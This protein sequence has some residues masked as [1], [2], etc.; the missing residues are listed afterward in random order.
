MSHVAA[1]LALAAALLLAT[2]AAAR[3]AE[4]PDPLSPEA[5]DA[6]IQKHRTAQ[7]TLTVLG[8]DGR[9]AAERKVTVAMERHAFLFGCN[10]FALRPKDASEK[11]KA[12][13]ERFA[14][15]L[16]YATLG[17]YWGAFEREEGK[18]NI[19]G[20]RAMAAWCR[21]KNIATKG[22]PLAWHTVVPKWLEGR[23]AEDVERL[24]LGRITRDVAAMK[25][26]V[27]RW[28]VVNE[29]VVMPG[30]KPANAISELGKSLGPVEF[31]R[32]MFAAARAADPRATL[33]L[34]DYDTSPR[35]ERLIDDCLKA[36]V[37]IDVVGIQSHM[38]TGY[39]GAAKAWDVCERFARFGKPLHFTELTI[40]SGTAPK[41]INWNERHPDWVGTPE[42]EALQE[43]QVTEFYRI[44]FSHPAVHAIT[45]WDFSDAGAWMAA[46]A[47]LVRADMS[48]KPAYESLMKLVKGAWWTVPASIV[49]DEAGRATFRGFLGAYSVH[50]DG[51]RAAFDVST[52]G[53]AAVTVR[54]ASEAK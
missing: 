38:H 24:Q 42:G 21:E 12:Y 39:W 10:I 5:I 11:Q 20:V 9:P 41:R 37:P 44:L 3:A 25:D 29:A 45:W 46:P 28:D 53:A 49:T 52:P 7:V 40:Q 8:P 6:R 16:N 17:F 43:R 36:G 13:Q 51:V 4:D 31:I 23:P 33:L 19:D 18:P 50:A 15:L 34:N 26:L 48:P 47:G 14:A 35:Y 2:A 1:T 54:L 27:A 22:H 30:Y 32:R